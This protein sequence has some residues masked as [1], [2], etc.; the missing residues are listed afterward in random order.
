MSRDNDDYYRG[1]ISPYADYSS[2]AHTLGYQQAQ[3]QRDIS[4]GRVNT[5]AGRPVGELMALLVLVYLAFAAWAGIS[6]IASAIPGWV[7]WAVAVILAFGASVAFADWARENPDEA[8]AYGSF[9]AGI[10][11][12]VY[13]SVWLGLATW[14]GSLAVAVAAYSWCSV[15]A[16]R[17]AHDSRM[18]AAES[19]RANIRLVETVRS[20]NYADREELDEQ[21]RQLQT[22]SDQLFLGGGYEACDSTDQEIKDLIRRRDLAQ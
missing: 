2:P 21:I 1:F 22:I 3:L 14:F 6:W 19:R 15:R 9:A 4:A 17:Q 18:V 8:V 12:S 16:R 11:V 20:Q 5:G 7:W 13:S 10:T